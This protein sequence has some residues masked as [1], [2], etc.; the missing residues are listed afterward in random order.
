[1]DFD[2]ESEVTV[3]CGATE[4]MIDS[5]LALVDPGDEVVVLEPF[6]ENY[7]PDTAIDGATPVF[8]RSGAGFAIDE[9][10]LGAAFGPKTRAIVLNTPN[11]P[12]G[13]VYTDS[14]LRAVADLCID[15]DT[16]AFVDEIYEHILFDGHRHLS[17]GSLPGM[18]ERTVT[19][20]SFS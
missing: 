11:N 5:M 7:G 2:P 1:M 17:L 6:Y 4:A 3:G 19:I 8:V 10:A 15:H 20:G 18:E 14:E 16:Y 12:P 9:D 13:R